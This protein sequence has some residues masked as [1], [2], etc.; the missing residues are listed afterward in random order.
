MPLILF[1]VEAGLE[2]IPKSI[3]T[4][5]S[6]R[7]NFKRN[8]YSSQLLDN[9]LHHTAMK[10]LT[11]SMKRG[12]PDI[13]HGCLLNALGSP[14]NKSGHLKLYLH[15]IQDRMFEFNPKI[16]ITRNF[17]RFKGLISKLLIDGKIV[18]N[19]TPLI[20]EI[21]LELH[22]LIESFHSTYV[23]LL[24]EKGLLM[25]EPLKLF[26][27]DLQKDQIVLIGGF[28]KGDFSSNIQSLTNN[29]LSI[30]PHSL[31]AWNV[32]SKVISIYEIIHNIL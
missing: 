28:Q 31:D 9:A 7:E 5:S 11:D 17:N 23:T 15:T 16:K 30:S 8:N 10:G 29:K 27:Q 6:I 14:L 19:G 22:A 3:R 12:R 1:I 26:L 13:I 18:L 2:L 4:H 25:E 20:K 32:V 24:T 21:D